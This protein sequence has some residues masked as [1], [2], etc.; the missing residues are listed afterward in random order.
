MVGVDERC[1]TTAARRDG[2]MFV[3]S[4]D[5]ALPCRC[6]KCNAEA[7]GPRIF[8]TI[9]LLSPWYPLFS[10]GGWNAHCA[11]ERP[12]HITY[13]LCLR[14]R[15][16]RLVRQTLIGFAAMMNVMGFVLYETNSKHNLIADLAAI[17][18]PLLL[19]AA[20]VTLRPILR[21]RRVHHGLAWFTG[22]GT[23]FLDSL[24]RMEQA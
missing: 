2:M 16:Q 1:A 4:P 21:P 24:P 7:P 6:V 8:R 11:D 3:L 17:L 22:A 12:I 23:D 19:I 9:S 15:L 13:S 18:P 14:H 5:S 10:S 20:A